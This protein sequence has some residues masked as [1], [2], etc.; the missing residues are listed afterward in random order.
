M[1]RR[2]T[3]KEKEKLY[4]LVD[5]MNPKE[6]DERLARELAIK[7]RFWLWVA[8]LFFVILKANGWVTWSWWGVTAPIWLQVVAAT[9]VNLFS[10]GKND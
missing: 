9:A 6:K 3:D 2:L 5:K 7:V 4:N 8:F 10:G 1:S